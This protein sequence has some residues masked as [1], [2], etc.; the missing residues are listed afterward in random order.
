M[1]ASDGLPVVGAFLDANGFLQTVDGQHGLPVAGLLQNAVQALG[2]RLANTT[3][4]AANQAV[5]IAPLA[6]TAA[7]N[8]S[9]SVITSNAHGLANGQAINISGAVGNTAINGTW[10]VANATANTFTLT[11]IAGVPVAGNGVWASGGS[12]ILLLT[13]PGIARMAGGRGYITKAKLALD[14]IAMVGTWRLW[15]YSGLVTP[16]A[17]QAT[18]TLLKVNNALRVGYIDITTVTG[19]AGSDC[20]FGEASGGSG[21]LPLEFTADQ[22]GAI[23]GMLASQ[24]AATPISGGTGRI[25]L[26]ADVY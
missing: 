1:R 18:F 8:A 19:G 14:G 5:N 9:P 21:N 2:A 6:V 15:L 17:D 25:V 26:S 13:F 11:D 12:I 4:Y 24:G 3:A 16:L 20:S 10:L 23:Y 7:T 22:N